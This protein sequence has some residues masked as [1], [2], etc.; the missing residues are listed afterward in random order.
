MSKNENKNKR[1]SKFRQIIMEVMFEI[2]GVTVLKRK[3]RK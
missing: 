1:M 2:L 3:V